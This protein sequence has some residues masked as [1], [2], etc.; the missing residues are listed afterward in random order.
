MALGPEVIAKVGHCEEAR[1]GGLEVEAE[2]VGGAGGG[3]IR[4]E[5]GAEA[6]EEGGIGV[7]EGPP[8]E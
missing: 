1:S 8:G 3:G 2:E 5:A 4:G 7:D 6:V